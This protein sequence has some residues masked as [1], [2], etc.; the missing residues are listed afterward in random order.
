[1]TL[2]TKLGLA[3]GLVLAWLGGG[4]ILAGQ[5]RFGMAAVLF[6]A[7]ALVLVYAVRAKGWWNTPPTL[8]QGAAGVG[9][10]ASWVA[11]AAV[12]LTA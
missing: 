7:P 6:S 10:L 4:L 5:T 12:L 9:V 11:A 3:S 1:M 8:A 2:R